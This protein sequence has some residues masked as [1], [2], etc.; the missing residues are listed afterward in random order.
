MY[1]QSGTSPPVHATAN[2]ARFRGARSAAV[3]LAS[4]GVSGGVGAGAG[5]GAAS[6]VFFSDVFSSTSLP[7]PSPSQTLAPK[8]RVAPLERTAF[9]DGDSA[10]HSHSMPADELVKSLQPVPSAAGATTGPSARRSMANPTT[11]AA[12]MDPRGGDINWDRMP[13]ADADDDPWGVSESV[14]Y[15]RVP[16]S[17][18]A[19][20]SSVRLLRGGSNSQRDE[21]DYAMPVN[22]Y[23]RMEMDDDSLQD[24]QRRFLM[25]QRSFNARTARPEYPQDYD[26]MVDVNGYERARRARLQYT[27]AQ[28]ELLRERERQHYGYDLPA[29]NGT[30][31]GARY[32]DRARWLDRETEF[33]QARRIHRELQPPRSSSA[34][35]PAHAMA[36]A[37]LWRGHV[38]EAEYSPGSR[39]VTPAAALHNVHRTTRSHQPRA[40]QPQQ[41]Q[42]RQQPSNAPPTPS[43]YVPYESTGAPRTQQLRNARPNADPRS[44]AARDRDLEVDLEPAPLMA[45]D[46]PERLPAYHREMQLQDQI[47]QRM[48]RSQAFV[49]HAMSLATAGVSVFAPEDAPRRMA[50]AT[51]PAPASGNNEYGLPPSPHPQS[52]PAVREAAATLP[53]PIESRPERTLLV[54]QQQRQQRHEQQEPGTA[55]TMPRASARRS[56]GGGASAASSREQQPATPVSISPVAAG[57]ASAAAATAT[58]AATPSAGAVNGNGASSAGEP[59]RRCGRKSMNYSSEQK[60]ERNRAA[61]KKCRQRQALKYDYLRRKAEVLASENLALSEMLVKS[62]ELDDEKRV[63]LT[64]GIQMDILLKIKEIFTQSL[65][66]DFVLDADSIWDLN[67]VLAV[68]MPARCYYGIESI[69]D[70]WRTSLRMRNKGKIRSFWAWLFRLPPG[71]RF[72][73][74]SIKPFAMDSNLYFINWT[75]KSTPPLS[76]AIVIMFGH[77]HRVTLHVEV[78]GWLIWR[79]LLTNTPFPEPSME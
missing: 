7:P 71:D 58:A 26:D 35:S 13:L 34:S 6:P 1:S 27:Y 48:A 15:R 16:G 40:V 28:E 14:G 18:R 37:T 21:D 4:V 19:T 36:M 12:M 39:I 38:H 44:Y 76:G 53:S 78:F 55:A 42:Q 70:F 77:G 32:R 10:F 63:S 49:N 74:F 41:P 79:Y 67:S 56:A 54:Q 31:G 5:V 30:S 47:E 3:P 64:R 51:P 11:M 66:K 8:T 62:V 52:G 29:E 43:S 17:T 57:A 61:V 2:A 25:A 45:T 33:S 69:K 23:R 73:S 50:L 60:R 65:P 68:S 59:K 46:Y 20:A 75:T 9:L 72:L 24:Q 22:K